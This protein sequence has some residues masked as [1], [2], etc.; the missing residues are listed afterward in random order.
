MSLD[1]VRQGVQARLE[2]KHRA[3]EVGLG[4]A[5]QA[6][7]R[8][9]NAIRAV[10][11]GELE[12]ADRLLVEARE[13]LDV[14]EATLA[15]HPDVY[16]AGFLQ[17]AQK[18]YAEGLA[19]RALVAGA[20]LPPPEDTG[21]GDAPYLN[22]LAEAIGELRRHLLDLLRA[23][24]VARADELFTAME[25]IHAVLADVD[26]PDAMTGGLRRSTDVARSIIERTRSD[27]TLTVVQRDLA[28]ALRRRADSPGSSTLEEFPGGRRDERA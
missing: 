16:Y 11:R 18:E 28:D 10:H 7:R 17:D 21:V 6:T 12:L 20:P 5:R 15:A 1:D 24:D 3:R 2:A 13:L 8:C 22:G 23:G 26:F 9:A 19:T 27:L 14:A 25:E 4:N